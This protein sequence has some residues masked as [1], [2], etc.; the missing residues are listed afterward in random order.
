VPETNQAVIEMLRIGLFIGLMRE[1][2]TQ[3]VPTMTFSRLKV[4]MFRSNG[5]PT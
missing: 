3:P 4:V 1:F 2:F 5:S